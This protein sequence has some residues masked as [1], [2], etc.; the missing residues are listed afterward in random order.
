MILF[1]CAV[2]TLAYFR[3]NKA[4]LSFSLLL[5]HD[6]FHHYMAKLS[7]GNLLRNMRPLK[8]KVKSTS[9]SPFWSISFISPSQTFSETFSSFPALSISLSSSREMDLE[10]SL[11]NQSKIL[12]SFSLVIK[13]ALF[14]VARM[15]SS[16]QSPTSK[17]IKKEK[18]DQWEYHCNQPFPS[19]FGPFSS[20]RFPLWPWLLPRPRESLCSLQ[21]APNKRVSHLHSS[22]GT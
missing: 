4:F 12:S 3:R 10:P 16:S 1:I 13:L 21:P 19:H 17:L 8:L 22:P 14:T 2:S 15:N 11:S 6:H 9:P 18:L 20:S 7:E 5:V